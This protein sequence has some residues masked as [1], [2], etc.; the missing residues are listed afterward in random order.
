MT[1]LIYMEIWRI[2]RIYITLIL[3]ILIVPVLGPVGTCLKNSWASFEYALSMMTFATPCERQVPQITSTVSQRA[4]KVR[5]KQILEVDCPT[6]NTLPLGRQESAAGAVS[7][8]WHCPGSLWRMTDQRE[9]KSPELGERSWVCYLQPL[10]RCA[11]G[12]LLLPC[13]LRGSFSSPSSPQNRA[14]WNKIYFSYTLEFARWA[15]E[16]LP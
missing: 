13:R 1:H 7:S 11:V 5:E 12:S 9:G 15:A 3:S 10:H 16:T 8:E 2:T 14:T 6:D 4:K